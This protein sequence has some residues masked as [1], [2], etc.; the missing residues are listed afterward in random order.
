VK[1]ALLPIGVVMLSLV[2]RTASATMIDLQGMGKS[3]AVQVSLNSS[4]INITAGEYK[5]GWM[6]TTPSGYSPTFYSYCVDLLTSATDPEN[7]TL[8]ST[9]LLTVSGVPDAGKKAAWLFN[10]YA[11]TINVSGTNTDAAALQVAI[12]EA[13][14]DTSASLTGGAFH[15]LTTG[16]VAT[17]A[18]QYLTA[19]YSGPA[20][21]YQTST[22]TWLDAAIN[23]GQDQVTQTATVPEPGTLVLCGLGLATVV[24]K[25]RRTRGSPPIA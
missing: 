17:K 5:W 18:M 8:K 10:T 21:G 7:V 25:L 3:S 20:G 15:L 6:G 16:A 23:S 13:L 4:T 11:P 24:R 12:W 1:R 19:L 22:A 2:A 9:N 14:Y